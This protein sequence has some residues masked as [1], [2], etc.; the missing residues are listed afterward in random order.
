MKNLGGPLTPVMGVFWNDVQ[1]YL[2]W[3]N[4][5]ARAAGEPWV[6]DL[7]TDQEWEKA[8]RGVDGRLFPW[9]NRFDFANVVGLFSPSW[10]HGLHDA[11]GGFEPR[12]E[13]PFGVQDAAGHRQEWTADS[14]E[15]DPNAPPLYRWRGGCW[16]YGNEIDFRAASRGFG[17][18]DYVGGT[19]GFRLVA[20][21][22]P[23]VSTDQ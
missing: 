20:R 4:A 6:Y 18:A 21:M 23:G 22:R 7:P 10:L 11:P 3:R 19:I 8:A 1:D 12:D 15:T 2:A 16:R 13:S 5:R 17:N 9:G 14:Y